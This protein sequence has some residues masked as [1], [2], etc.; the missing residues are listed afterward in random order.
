MDQVW[1]PFKEIDEQI[2]IL[3]GRGLQIPDEEDAKAKLLRYNYNTLVNGY[4]YPFLNKNGD[5]TEQYKAGASFDEL[6]ALY[7]FDC[8]F[9]ALLFKYI[10]KVEHQLKSLISHYFSRKHPNEIYPHYL[11]IKNFDVDSKGQM[12]G[13]KKEN[14]DELYKRITEEV[15]HQLQNNNQLLTHYQVNYGNIPPWILVSVLSFGMLRQ[16]Y[17][18]MGNHDQNEVAKAFGRTL[19]QVNSYLSA[20]NFYRNACAH[21]ERIYN[22]KLR[23]RV[24]RKNQ[25][26]EPIQYN[27]V[28]VLILILKDMLDSASFMDFYSELND[29]ISLLEN[30][31]HTI[32]IKTVLGAMGMPVHEAVRKAELGPLKQ[33]NAL[34]NAE[35]KEVLSR[36]ILPILAINTQLQPADPSDRNKENNVCRLVWEYKPTTPDKSNILYFAQATNSEFAYYV[37]LQKSLMSSAQIAEIEEHLAGLIN[38]IHIFWNLSNLSAYSRN[39]VA[40][41]FPMLCEQAYE[42]S[43]CHLLCKRN[44]K[45]ETIKHDKAY[46]KF[47]IEFEKLN[48]EQRLSRRQALQSSQENLSKLLTLEGIA[49]RTLYNILTQIEAWAVK[50]Y[51]GQK[52]TFGIILCTDSMLESGDTFDYIDFLKSDYSATIND[53]FYSAVELYANGSFKAHKT[54]NPIINEQLPSIPY[55]FGGF[56]ELCTQDKIGVLLTSSGD[57][58]IIQDQQLCYTK[59]NGRWLRGM[60]NKVISKI[61]EELELDSQKYA[62]TIYQSIVDV[63]YSRGGAC[64]GIIKDNELPVRLNEMIRAGL[65]SDVPEDK[66]LKALK[67]MIS[68]VDSNQVRQ[69]SFFELDR[70]L[71]RE[72]LEF[73][74]AMV[75]S[76]GG[77]IHVIGT[78]IKLD[79][80]GSEGGGRTAAAMQLSE[81]GLAIKISQD[82]YVQIFKN[83]EIVMKIMT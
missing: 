15:A 39:Q 33:G 52:K 30:E 55:P 3:K 70:A 79:G 5:S 46:Q 23:N 7:T 31:L 29:Y 42:L 38:Y 51:E 77:Q 78:I 34:S 65:L 69:K 72:L 10:L 36:Y 17:E 1:K 53:G 56:A 61:Q 68:E 26:G 41:A 45:E 21:D 44:S 74:G 59:H 32:D 82:G 47:N 16:F 4:N 58:L 48:L 9:R 22:K 73:D 64:I 20:L 76:K 43:I 37:P 40:S 71:R 60:A 24:V 54:V 49:E 62:E 67:I 19:D 28:Y 63:S 8:N 14:Y 18:C 50:T 25:N 66:K 57:I 83:R 12:Y 6:F 75:L 27:R 80:S 2:E 13:R 11:D 35:F 81:F